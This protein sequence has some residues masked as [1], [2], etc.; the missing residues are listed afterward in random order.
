MHLVQMWVPPNEPGLPPE[1][2]ELDVESELAIG[3]LVPVAS[4][5]KRHAGDAAIGIRNRHTAF[6]AARLGP[7]QSVTVS[8]APYV[9]IF[10][11]EGTVDMEGVG[12][13]GQGDAV[14]LASTGGQRISTIDSA[15]VL[16]WEMH[17]GFARN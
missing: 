8:E 6:Y 16:V 3:G 15:E 11:A 10:V 9:H 7:G 2:Q 13:L 12:P 14:R 1:Y 5:L 4:G 17:A